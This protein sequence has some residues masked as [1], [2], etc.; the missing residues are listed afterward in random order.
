MSRRRN[1][2]TGFT[3][4]ELL[5]VMGIAALLL[6]ISI[7]VAKTIT[8]GNHM[9]RCNAQL[10]QIGRALKMYHLDYQGVP[11]CYPVDP[12][13]TTGDPA[14]ELAGSR[15]RAEEIPGLVWLWYAGYMGNKK[16]L[17]CPRDIHHQDGSQLEFYESYTSRDP[18]AQT[19][20]GAN[21]ELFNNYKYLST[22]GVIDP[23]DEDYYR[24]LDPA[25]FNPGLGMVAPAFDTTWH[26]DDTTVVTW[27]DWH[28]DSVIR[29]GYGQY[30]VLFW[31]GSVRAL[32]EWL[33]N[34]DVDP[35]DEDLDVP[36]AAW[37]VRPTVPT[38]PEE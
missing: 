24:Q 16:T 15:G 29:E 4:T 23:D 26:P 3:L 11:A 34:P 13:S 2:T 17:H 30:L 5:V 25:Y 22:R 36:D 8:E 6:A 33:F 12:S 38:V 21:Y 14:T 35:P 19:Q 27:C 10:Q 9:A 28:A 37:R 31:D 18:D 20:S 7:P 1:A 32:P